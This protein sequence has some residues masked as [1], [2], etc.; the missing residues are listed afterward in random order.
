MK[1]TGD[2]RRVQ[3]VEKEVLQI[4]SRF[5]M[6]TFKGDLPGIVTVVGFWIVG[7]R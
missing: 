6:Q 2:G 7:F 1:K 3:R 4:L 5:L